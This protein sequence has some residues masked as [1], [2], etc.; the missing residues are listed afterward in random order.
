MIDHLCGVFIAKIDPERESLG[1]RKKN[2]NTALVRWVSR[3][4]LPPP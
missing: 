2:L 4:G 3:G 1:E